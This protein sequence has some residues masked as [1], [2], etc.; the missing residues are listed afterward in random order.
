[1]TWKRG[2]G[3]LGIFDPLLGRWRAESESHMG[4][5]ACSRTFTKELDGAYIQLTADWEYEKGSYKEIALIGVGPEGKVNFWSFTSDKKQS[6]GYLA[7]V[8]DIHPDAIGFEAQ[9]PAGLARMAYWPDDTEGFHWA[10]ES[11]TKKGW[12]RFT[13]HHYQAVSEAR[14]SAT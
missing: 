9:M 14:Y 4:K 13:E 12:N 1:M 2:R 7:D 3:K 6:R 10:V 5:V 8:T 11:K